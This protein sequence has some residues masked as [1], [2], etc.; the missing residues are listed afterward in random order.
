MKA[1][2]L[3]FGTALAL[4][5]AALAGPGSAPCGSGRVT[6]TQ[7][8]CSD[9]AAEADRKDRGMTQEENS[10]QGTTTV[11]HGD[12]FASVT[13]SGDPA[14]VERRIEKRPGYTKLEQRSGSSRSVIVQS[15][16]PADLPLDQFPHAFRELFRK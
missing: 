12:S 6:T 2:Y 16:D 1:A 3:V 10:G 8:V 14:T 9:K 7:S 15:N 5:A 11:R 4:S 13:Q